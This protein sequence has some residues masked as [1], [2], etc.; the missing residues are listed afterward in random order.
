MTVSPH[1]THSAAEK[2]SIDAQQ[3]T[4]AI[5]GAGP[6]GVLLAYMLAR[7]GIDVTLLEAHHD[8]DR[9]FRGDTL[10]PS[11]LE[12]MDELGLADKLLQLPHTKLRRLAAQSGMGLVNVIDFGRLKTKFPYV[13]FMPQA[14][15]LEFVTGEA[16]RFPA[17]H[18]RMGAR[19]DGLLEE[20]DKVCGVSYRDANGDHQLR[21]VLTIGTDGRFSTI[22]KLAGFATTAVKASPPMD[23]LWFRLARR[24]DD[25]HG[26][27][28]RF[29]H[30]YAL[31]E[32]ERGAQWQIAFIIPK[33]SYPQLHSA[34]IEALRQ[35]VVQTAPEFADRITELDDWKQV[36][37]LSVEADRLPRW[38]KPGLL[39]LGDA[40]HVMSPAGGNGINYAIMDAVAAANLLHVPLK[41]GRVT[42]ADL[43]RVQ[44]RRMVPTRVI[45]TV[46]N[47]MQERVLRPAL[48]PS[49]GFTMPRLLRWPVVG[50]MAARLMGFGLRREHVQDGSVEDAVRYSQ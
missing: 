22:R 45:Q 12:V 5:V 19:V 42:V 40:A 9:D 29:G 2:V 26:A 46:A 1:S 20:D 50:D 43:A 11:T 47:L 8:F 39:L 41:A 49:K 7:H 13:A 6:A 24:P 4:C 36:S 48:D 23:V 25:P 10:H 15:F 34:G 17:F 44:R 14:R 3:T 21:A 28:G 37:L 27:L 32:L 18:L 38:Y 35:A 16:Q 30:G 33:G 31:V